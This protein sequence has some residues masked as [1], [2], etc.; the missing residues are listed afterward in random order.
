MGSASLASV[1][2]RRRLTAV[3]DAVDLRLGPGGGLEIDAEGRQG[4]RRQKGDEADEQFDQ[5]LHREPSL[6]IPLRQP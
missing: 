6:L 4:G 1:F 5:S 2:R 3:G